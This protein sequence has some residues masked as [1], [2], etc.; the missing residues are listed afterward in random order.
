MNIK[1]Y[2]KQPARYISTDG[3]T[4]QPF[5]FLLKMIIHRGVL[6][7]TYFRKHPYI[8]KSLVTF[9]QSSKPFRMPSE[10]PLSPSDCNSRISGTNSLHCECS[11]G[12]CDSWGPRGWGTHPGI[13][14]VGGGK[15]SN[16]RNFYIINLIWNRN[17]ILIR[18]QFINIM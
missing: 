3:V 16:L 7:G 18:F 2:F 13:H 14:R 9:Y 6:G 12:S 1:K 10:L 17:I 15:R 11:S 8:N 4:K 5:V